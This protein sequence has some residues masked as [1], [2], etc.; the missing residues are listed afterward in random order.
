M[1]N[2]KLQRSCFNFRFSYRTAHEED[3]KDNKHCKQISDQRWDNVIEF[4]IAPNKCKDKAATQSV[5]SES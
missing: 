3:S 2:N 5:V 4:A 1:K